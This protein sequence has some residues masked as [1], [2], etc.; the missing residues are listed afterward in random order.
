MPVRGPGWTLRIGLGIGEAWRTGMPRYYTIARPS[1]SDTA[2]A[3]PTRMA[4]RRGRRKRMS[5]NDE[6][7][8]GKRLR[9]VSCWHAKQEGPRGKARC[10]E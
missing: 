7:G 2:A 10:I 4:R 1:A 8:C 9:E 6:I 3:Q 5:H